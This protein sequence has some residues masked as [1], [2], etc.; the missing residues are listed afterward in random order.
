MTSFATEPAKD[1]T[2]KDSAQAPKEATKKESPKE[3]V[4][5]MDKELKAKLVTNRE[6]RTTVDNVIAKNRNDAKKCKAETK[7]KKGRMLITWEIDEKG[8][9]RSF[10]KGEDTIENEKLY[11]CL[12]HK[13]EKWKFG[14]PPYERAMDIEHLFVL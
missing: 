7:A 14:A 6:Y 4:D 3:T 2:A 12:I 10:S 1:T 5:R 9:A 11:H 8:Q 13:I